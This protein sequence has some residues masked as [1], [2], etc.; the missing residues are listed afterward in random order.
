MFNLHVALLSG[1]QKPN[2][3]NLHMALLSGVP[4]NSTYKNCKKPVYITL[5]CSNVT[6][7]LY[8][9]NNYTQMLFLSRLFIYCVSIVVPVEFRAA[10]S[11]QLV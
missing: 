10:E 6:S 5:M 4:L 3:F 7:I 9:Y 2:M 1:V 8:H 11:Q